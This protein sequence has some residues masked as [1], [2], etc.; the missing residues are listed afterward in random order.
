MMMTKKCT[1]DDLKTYFK[2]DALGVISRSRMAA[3][4]SIELLSAAAAYLGLR[5]TSK[6][7]KNKVC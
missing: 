1:K 3:S 5:T 7:F 2:D 6:I 4:V